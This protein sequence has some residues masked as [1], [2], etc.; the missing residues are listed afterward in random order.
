MSEHYMKLN[1]TYYDKGQNSIVWLT[2]HKDCYYIGKEYSLSANK[3]MDYK[4]PVDD[5]MLIEIDPKHLIEA[6]LA[7]IDMLYTNID[8]ETEIRCEYLLQ[9]YQQSCPQH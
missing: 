3:L 7:H 4:M 8:M 2:G 6:L 9:E 1:C 5:A